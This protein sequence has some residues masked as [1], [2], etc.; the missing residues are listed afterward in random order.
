MPA[1][2]YPSISLH[3]TF[4]CPISLNPIFWFFLARSLTS[5]PDYWPFPWIHISSYSRLL[6][7]A[8]KVHDQMPIWSYAHWGNFLSLVYFKAISDCGYSVSTISFQFIILDQADI[9]HKLSS[10]FFFC[11]RWF[12]RTPAQNLSCMVKEE[13]GLDLSE[14]LGN[15]DFL[16]MQLTHTFWP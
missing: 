10:D 7:M 8:H 12:Y 3:L 2:I 14:S 1:V 4:P 13:Y 15:L 16:C 11:L 5:W 6:F 9:T